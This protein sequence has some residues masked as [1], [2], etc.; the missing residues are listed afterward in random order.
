M[1]NANWTSLQWISFSLTFSMEV[2][3]GW[4]GTHRYSGHDPNADF[5]YLCIY[6]TAQCF[7]L[8][9]YYVIIILRGPSCG[10]RAGKML[11]N[12]VCRSHMAC[13]ERARK[14]ESILVGLPN[15]WPMSRG[16]EQA[17][18]TIQLNAENAI[19][20]SVRPPNPAHNL[21]SNAFQF[22]LF[23]RVALN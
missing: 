12:F 9:N 8:H 15:I 2:G 6:S 14:F 10:R 7:P 16:P 3:R 18:E 4:D 23:S 13:R 19:S 21:N 11:S 22:R 17:G 5:N 1:E 20:P